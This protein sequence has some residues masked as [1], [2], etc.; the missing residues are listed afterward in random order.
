MQET[1]NLLDGEYIA[2]QRAA[3]DEEQ[4]RAWF[5]ESVDLVMEVRAVDPRDQDSV[6]AKT[7][8]FAERRQQL[9]HCDP[10]ELR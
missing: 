9:P 7:A 1:A 2:R 10:G 3:V 6:R 4:R 8:V 5:S